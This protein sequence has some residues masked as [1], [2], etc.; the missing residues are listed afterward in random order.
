MA[1]GSA[2]GAG[3]R[4]RFAVGA[5]RRSLNFR[6]HASA[7]YAWRYAGPIPER[8]TIAPIDLRTA[9][10]TAA[11]DIFGG[12]W[13]FGGEG[14]DIEGFSVFDAVAPSEQWAHE[15]HAFGWLRHLRAIEPQDARRRARIL[16]DEWINFSSHHDA[17]A[18]DPEV[19]ARRL[20][21]WF[22]QAPMI[23]A[24]CDYSFYRRFMRSVTKQVRYLRRVA[25]DSPP[26]LPRLRIMIALAT[27]ALSM[28][29]QPRFLRQARRRLDLELVN[30]VLPDGGHVSRNPGAVLEALTD[31]LPLRQA[32]SMQGNQPSHV[33]VSAVDRMMP[34]LRFFR[35]GDGGLARFNGHSDRPG[36]LAATVLAYDDV[37]GALPEAAAQSGFH[38]V[39]A[40]TTALIVDTG[41]PP[42]IDFSVQAHASCLAFE[43]SVGHQMLIV[44]CG[45]PSPAARS[46]SR[47]A[48]TSAAHSTVSIN[49]TSS[50][51][52]LH[53]SSSDDWMGDVIVAGPERVDVDRRRA[54]DGTALT[55]QHDGWLNRF[56]LVHR[57]ALR[58]TDEGDMLEGRDSFV[59]PSGSPAQRSGKDLF[60][61]RFHVHPNVQ[62]R[63]MRETRSVILEMPGGERWEF[64]ADAGDLR[65][66]ESI[67]MSVNRGNRETDQ[68]VI[69]G[70]V[71]H[72]PQVSWRLYRTGL[73][74]HRGQPRPEPETHDAPEE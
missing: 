66:E 70:R 49:D 73:G 71:Q 13:V 36:D 15:L 53:S 19:T 2:S 31:L 23:L 55:A 11:H 74:R 21:A 18:W 63:E 48:R 41:R 9:D 39:V 65:I 34:M 24:D 10:P 42:Q 64:E 50:C 37:R 5:F 4:V 51:R 47:L 3:R 72:T 7:L 35:L 67:L 68:I 43:M 6:L 60:T 56:G 61:I 58:L 1:I 8:L 12:R 20:I 16:V 28:S 52:F 22:S 54:G 14:L 57:R 17:I 46:L 32:F 27:A 59:S 40:N 62:V 29:D 38:K 26:G 44:N 25:Y 33:L 30:Q 69:H 45:V